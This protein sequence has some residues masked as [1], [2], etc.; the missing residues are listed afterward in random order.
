M[1][2]PP[3]SYI[4]CSTWAPSL[5]AKVFRSLLKIRLPVLAEIPLTEPIRSSATNRSPN[6]SSEETVKGFTWTGVVYTP[7]LFTGAPREI[8][9]LLAWAEALAISTAR[10]V[11]RSTSAAVT[12][13]VE[14]N[15]QE[16]FTKTRTPTPRD[17]SLLRVST[18]PV[19][20]TNRS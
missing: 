14:A 3:V 2:P 4:V 19:R 16:P 8:G 15:P 18:T 1:M 12:I 9:P 10:S 6:F 11:T 20:T 17:S 13:L 5:L 7:W